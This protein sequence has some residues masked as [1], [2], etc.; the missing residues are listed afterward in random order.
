VVFFVMSGIDYLIMKA[1]QMAHFPKNVTI[2]GGA[3]V[4]AVAVHIGLR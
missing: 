3:L 1:N 4:Y 2:A